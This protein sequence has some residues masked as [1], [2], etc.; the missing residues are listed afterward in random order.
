MRSQ[1]PCS[2]ELMICFALSC[3]NGVHYKRLGDDFDTNLSSAESSW[4]MVEF[5]EASFVHFP[6]QDNF[7]PWPFMPKEYCHCL[8]LS[9]CTLS[10]CPWT[11]LC[12]HNNSSQI[13]A[14]ITKFAPNLHRETLSAGIE[15]G[16][17]WRWPSRSCQLS[18]LK[19]SIQHRSCILI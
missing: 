6:F 5:N 17:H 4:C 9:V 2:W 15:N 14:R 16:G 11:L 3:D 13:W 12:P 7:T 19:N 10:I 8:C 1:P 18:I